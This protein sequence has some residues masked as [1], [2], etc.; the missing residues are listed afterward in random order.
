MSFKIQHKLAIKKIIEET[1]SDLD[2]VST[3]P[4][5]GFFSIPPNQTIGDQFYSLD[6]KQH[7]QIIEHKVITEKRGIYTACMK[8]GK[9][10]DAYFQSFDTTDE[11]VQ[12]RLMEGWKLDY[13]RHLMK[14]KAQKQPVIIPPFKPPGIQEIRD[15]TKED[16][17]LIK[18]AVNKSEKTKRRKINSKIAIPNRGIYTQIG[19]KGFNNTPGIYFSYIP[20]HESNETKIKNII[21]ENKKRPKSCIQR[22]TPADRNP[23]RP[24]SANQHECFSTI[25]ETY[26]Y[27]DKLYE[28]LKEISYRKRKNARKYKKILPS[29][30]V[31]HERPFSPNFLTK[32][33]RD[34]LFD[35]RIWDCPQIE[36]KKNNTICH[37]YRDD[38]KKK[39]PFKYNVMYEQ[40]KFSP[41][42]I[43]NYTNMRNNYPAIFGKS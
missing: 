24:P 21:K 7:H 40:S 42:I 9:G 30:S 14:I 26:G 37:R 43:M 36:E 10:P 31:I 2:S 41:S 12:K 13:Q 17:D 8:S 16:D 20:F 25:K 3:I 38:E 23:F 33:G 22:R 34:S 27:E 28:K 19:K 1:K 4:R 32:T 11:G 18:L 35:Q 39:L 5:F 29:H 6:K 15:V